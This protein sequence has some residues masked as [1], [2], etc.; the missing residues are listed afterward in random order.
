VLLV[1]HEIWEQQS[2][3]YEDYRYIECDAVYFNEWEERSRKFFPN[4]V[5]LHARLNIFVPSKTPLS[6]GFLQCYKFNVILVSFR[7]LGWR[8]G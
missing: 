4:V 6:I 8:I 5:V 7:G 1:L 2:C 3:D